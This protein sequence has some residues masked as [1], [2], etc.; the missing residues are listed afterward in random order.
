MAGHLKWTSRLIQAFYDKGV[1]HAIISPGSRSTPLTLA[2]AIHPG[3]EKKVILDERS[4]AFTALGIG[5]STG[6]PALLICTSGTAVANYF[7]AVVE[8]KESGVPMIVLSADRPPSLRGVG[9]SQT[10]DQIK[11]FGNYAV[12]F[13]EPGEPKS[14]TERLQYAAKQAF[15]QSIEN[16][17]ASHIN[18]PFAKPLEPSKEEFEEVIEHLT[19][20]VPERSVQPETVSKSI[21]LG[22]EIEELISKSTKPL[23]IAGP[24]NPYHSLWP[25]IN[26]FSKHLNAPVIAEPGSGVEDH[27]SVLKRYEQYLRRDEHIENF[28]PDLIVRFGDQPFTKSVITALDSW[29]NVPLIHFSTRKSWQDHS[30]SIN[31]SVQLQKKDT[32]SLENV[33]YDGDDDW[34]KNWKELDHK[35]EI[36]QKELLKNE[37]ALTDAHI[38]SHIGRQMGQSWNIMLSNSFPP[39]DMA[40]FGKPSDKLFVNRGAA[41]IDGIISTALGIQFSNNN[42]VC[43]VVGDLA[44]LHDSNALYSVKY[45]K[46][47]FVIIV[48]NNGGGN[49]FKMLPIHNQQNDNPVNL[50]LFTDYFETPQQANIEFLA[51]ASGL[52]YQRISSI[53]HLKEIQLYQYNHSTVVECVTN[54]ETSMKL[55]QKL[56]NS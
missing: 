36:K 9:S 5:K 22:A 32:L 29:R 35:E 53:N 2:A 28:Q 23:I 21:G 52:H 10:I 55:R 14:N 44:F 24:A 47:P 12:F 30:L 51:K 40:M 31:Y 6:K 7:P 8:A 38:F 33:D 39:R 37:E 49:I 11:L 46:R 27:P 19:A 54:S 15:E 16:G 42:P 41:G 26:H 43:A 3:I 48:V 18:L 45:S 25:H 20:V 17:G 56:W 1:R 50:D 4:A 34:L 13:F